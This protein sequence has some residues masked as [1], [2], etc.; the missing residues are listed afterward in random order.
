MLPPAV[1]D[2]YHGW[3]VGKD[4]DKTMK[5]ITALAVLL[6]CAIETNAHEPVSFDDLMVAFSTDFESTEIRVETVAPGI[7]V[8]FGA[9]GNLIASV[10]DQGVL[11]V[12]SQY[13][14]MIPKIRATI[15]GLGGGGIDFAINTHWHF[16]H[17]GGNPLLGRDGTWIV[18]QANSRRMMAG[19]HLIDMVSV[20]YEQPPYSS[21]A[22]PV[23]TF[24][25]H[26]QMHF[27]GETIDLVHFSP[28]HTTGDT[29]VIF[30]NS[31]VV[32]MGDVFNAGYPFIDAGN[33]GDID[34]MILFCESVLARL[35]GDSIIVPGHGPVAGYTDMVD[36]I[37][38]LETIRNRIS[39]MIDDGKT[40][41]DVLAAAPAAEFDERYGDPTGLIDRAYMSLSR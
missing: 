5:R 36:Y 29:A 6:I 4:W 14:Q 2:Y 27:N 28:A 31:N 32:H 16:D 13:A 25:D 22:M 41:A 30:N 10:G 20:S 9:G 21:K 34:G 38:M 33:G 40:L 11:T 8:L 15:E 18:S 24:D 23:I 26:M 17:A 3:N 19:K 39:D 37:T 35:D 1:Q 12:D 7:H